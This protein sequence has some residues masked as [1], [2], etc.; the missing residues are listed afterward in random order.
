MVVGGCFV[1]GEVVGVDLGCKVVLF[2]V[3]V[4]GCGVLLLWVMLG[5]LLVW[6]VVALMRV[7]DGV[8]KLVCV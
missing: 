2:G 6:L 8:V 7:L 1:V 3:G 5:V 4:V